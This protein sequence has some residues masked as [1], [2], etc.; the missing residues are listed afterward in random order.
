MWLSPL[1]NRRVPDAAG[2]RARVCLYVNNTWIGIAQDYFTRYTNHDCVMFGPLTVAEKI[3]AAAYITALVCSCGTETPFHLT[4][5]PSAMST[6]PV[7][8]SSSRDSWA[9]LANSVTT[10]QT[11]RRFSYVRKYIIYIHLKR[12]KNAPYEPIPR[13]LRLTS[14]YTGWGHWLNHFMHPKESPTPKVNRYRYSR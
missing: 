1:G 2:V 4:I 7:C 6:L 10:F 14:V 13:F 9:V 5:L 3:A 12:K 8:M 11:P